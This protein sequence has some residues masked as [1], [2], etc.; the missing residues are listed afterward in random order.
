[1]SHSLRILCAVIVL[2]ACGLLLMT[3]NRGNGSQ[4]PNIILMISDDQDYEHFGFMGHKIVQTPT[5]DTTQDMEAVIHLAANASNAQ[6]VST[7]SL[8][9]IM[10]LKTAPR[11]GGPHAQVY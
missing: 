9:S 5:L 10:R 1:M 7:V 2:S 6:T 3:D 11:T 4:R 8:A